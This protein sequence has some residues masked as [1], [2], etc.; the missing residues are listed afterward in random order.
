[1]CSVSL[2]TRGISVMNGVSHLIISPFSSPSILLSPLSSSSSLLCPSVLC[3][4]SSCPSLPLSHSHTHSLP[5]SRLW[6]RH[7]PRLWESSSPSRP[8][9]LGRRL[10]LRKT[11]VEK[12][13]PRLTSGKKAGNRRWEEGGWES[14]TRAIQKNWRKRD[15][16]CSSI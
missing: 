2:N 14:A 11:K 3:P 9:V 13:R 5:L 12:S 10:C 16:A 8:A 4:L 6:L 1:M 15:R 7:M